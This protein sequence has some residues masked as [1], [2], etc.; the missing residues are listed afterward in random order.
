MPTIQNDSLSTV[1]FLTEMTSWTVDVLS[2]DAAIGLEA[3]ETFTT[4][5]TILINA[6]TGETVTIPAA[7]VNGTSILQL[8]DAAALGFARGDVY[9]LVLVP[10][11]SATS[12]PARHLRIK[13][14]A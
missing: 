7:T 11:V 3:G 5:T 13:V 4:A 6:V 8:I 10:N 2:V 14:V 1:P 12:K 9:D